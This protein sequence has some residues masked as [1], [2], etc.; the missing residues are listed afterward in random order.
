MSFFK[1]FFKNVIHDRDPDD[2]VTVSISSGQSYRR[3]AAAS[4][5]CNISS[6]IY[7]FGC[8]GLLLQV[9]GKKKPKYYGTIAPYPDFDPRSDASNLQSSIESSGAST[10]S[11]AVGHLPV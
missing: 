4:R 9:K 6:I 3:G 1:K 2:T 10:Y 11:S 7:I 8:F 5:T